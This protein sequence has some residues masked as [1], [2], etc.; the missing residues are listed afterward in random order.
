MSSLPA[1]EP[2]E[3][4]NALSGES[5]KSNAIGIRLQ[6]RQKDTGKLADF[7]LDAKEFAG[8]LGTIASKWNGTLV[9]SGRS[10]AM[11]AF[12]NPFQARSAGK[13]LQNKLRS[14]QHE[15]ASGS[16]CATIVVKPL[17]SE[18]STTEQL[19]VAMSRELDTAKAG[20]M[21]VSD[22]AFAISPAPS[23]AT[24]ADSGLPVKAN[25]S[26]LSLGKT[27]FGEAITEELDCDAIAMAANGSATGFRSSRYQILSEIGH[28]AMG[29]VYK[30]HD[31]VIDRI[32]ALKTIPVDIQ[33]SARAGLIER[34]QREAKAAGNLDH[35]NIITI[36]D[37]GE[38]DDLVYLTMQFVEGETFSA[39]LT[40]RKLISLPTLFSYVDQIC[41]AV[42]FAHQHGIVHRDLKP[43]NVMLTAQGT[44]KV[45]DFGIAKKG[46]ASMTQTGMVV[47]TPDFMAPEQ[48]AG[49]RVDH[50]AD[51]F[52]LGTM[53]YE[54]LTGERAFSGQTIT[55]VLYKVMNEDPI[56]PSAIEPSLPRGIDAI[57]QRAMAK[58]PHQRFQSC[59]EMREAFH[60][61]GL[62]LGKTY[63]TQ[64][65]TAAR[66]PGQAGPATS[67]VVDISATRFLGGG[68]A[69]AAVA[70]A[71][72]YAPVQQITIV[73]T[74]QPADK[75]AQLYT[76]IAGVTAAIAVVGLSVGIAVF[77]NSP[78][79]VTNSAGTQPSMQSTTAV[80]VSDPRHVPS[81]SS[82]TPAKKIDEVQSAV[83]RGVQPHAKPSASKNA[84]VPAATG[85]PPE[86]PVAL[87]GVETDSGFRKE[88]IPS[89]LD[90]ADAAYGKGDYR[91]AIKYYEIVL[92]MDPQN[93]KATAAK[94][95]ALDAQK[96]KR[97]R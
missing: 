65:A 67:N 25:G 20:K 36:F 86:P 13:S 22:E 70:P 38:E 78:Q 50:R 89:I 61:Q 72:E 28:G 76:W 1:P 77:R 41:A 49:R 62:L 60:Q 64:M 71:R 23:P 84:A 59:E 9:S 92:R 8:L 95:N 32:V 66:G 5:P 48:A 83:S 82:S 54:L 44:V 75:T 68:S 46:N 97:P 88:E 85:N 16:L 2:E 17:P 91:S 55:A 11:L 3:S 45:L 93:A 30:A 34:L 7:E 10:E 26:K 35:P 33:D 42:G 47:G 63:G 90:Q 96:D 4:L 79:H 18:P 57:I 24:V 81:S 39:L 94:S 12:H 52:A 80:P 74:A 40:G 43:S 73:E 27:A 29:V 14:Y 19:A 58:D 6:L 37:V 53:F 15:G 56:P 87:K 51:I 69:A 21:L 31:R